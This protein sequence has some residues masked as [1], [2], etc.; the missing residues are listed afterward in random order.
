MEI[1]EGVG[2]EKERELGKVCRLKKSLYGLKQA[3]R[4]WNIKLHTYLEK[5]GFT[6]LET[7][8][9]F[10]KQDG[11]IVAVYVD[12]LLIVANDQDAAK[13]KE[14]LMAE[15]TMTDLGIMSHY[16]GMKVT[17]NFTAKTAVM[18][19]THYIE[20]ILKKF[21]LSEM[22]EYKTPME[23]SNKLCKFEESEA[24]DQR[25]YQAMIGCVMFLMLCTRPDIAFAVGKLSQYSAN[26]KKPHLEAV[27][28]LY[29]YLKGTKELNLMFNGNSDLKL[30]G[31]VDSDWS[32]CLDTRR[33]TS[34]YC[35]SLG[36]AVISWKSQKQKTVTLSSA[37]AE[38]VWLSEDELFSIILKP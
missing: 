20:D 6:Q 8:H 2:L 31:F 17:F 21:N 12:D 26:P 1:P 34:G 5:I 37:E 14:Q 11:I 32:S 27:K 25:Q 22:K 3:P 15:F 36:S 30:V 38:T 29:G 16:L 18:S 19:Q 9:A 35:F 10:Y 7:D 23:H 13:V 24:C 28:H 33:S 4:C